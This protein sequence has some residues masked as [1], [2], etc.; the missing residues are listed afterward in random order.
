MQNFWFSLFDS[1]SH[2]FIWESR[3]CSF[4]LAFPFT[5]FYL[6]LKLMTFNLTFHGKL[7]TLKT[8]SNSLILENI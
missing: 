7:L 1:L 8:N 5:T 2:L 6:F 3:Y 4:I